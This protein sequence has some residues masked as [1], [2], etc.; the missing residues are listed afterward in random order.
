MQFTACKFTD[1]DCLIASVEILE[2]GN[3]DLKEGTT[4]QVLRKLGGKNR[5]QKEVRDKLFNGFVIRAFG[6]DNV[7]DIEENVPD[8][9]DQ[10]L[11]TTEPGFIGRLST[12]RVV[13]SDKQTQRGQ[14]INN[15]YWDTSEEA[16]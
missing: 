14:T 3:P 11:E 10:V 5:D 9:L 8:W 7:G 13:A 15:D 16:S 2:S 12:V 6:Y 4:C 1:S